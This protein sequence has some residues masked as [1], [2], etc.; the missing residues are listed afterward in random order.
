MQDQDRLRQREDAVRMRGLQRLPKKSG[1]HPCGNVENASGGTEQA[2]RGG[3][4][5]SGAEGES[6]GAD[7]LA[8]GHRAP[9]EPEHTGRGGRSRRRRETFPSAGS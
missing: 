5:I 3:E 6:L 8:G 4:G 7:H 2:I 9:C 1:M